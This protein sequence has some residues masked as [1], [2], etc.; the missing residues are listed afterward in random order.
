[1]LL[2]FVRIEV[3]V[4]HHFGYEFFCINRRLVSAPVLS[5]LLSGLLTE[6]EKAFGYFVL[7]IKVQWQDMLILLQIIN[8][9]CRAMHNLPNTNQFAFGIPRSNLHSMASREPD[10]YWWVFYKGGRHFIEHIFLYR[11]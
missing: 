9:A 1:M 6:G 4:E 8:R 3:G 2:N 11:R 5:S 7:I 10:G